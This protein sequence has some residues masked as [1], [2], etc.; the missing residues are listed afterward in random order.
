[1][2]LHTKFLALAA[3]AMLSHSV[4]AQTAGSWLWRVGA[5]TLKPMVSDGVLSAP[6][7]P[8]S[9]VDIKPS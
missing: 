1:M 4:F 6:S 9:R 5:T 3:V 2:K 7:L 8:D